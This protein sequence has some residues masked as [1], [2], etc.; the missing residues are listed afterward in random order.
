MCECR[1]CIRV[2]SVYFLTTSFPSPPLSPPR[3]QVLIYNGQLDIIVGPPLT[4]AYLLV[5]PWSGKTEYLSAVKSV[6]RINPSDTDTAGY[7]RTVG[8]FTQVCTCAWILNFK[9]Q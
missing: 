4:E 2:A 3:H 6:W 8:N 5:L 1:M 9:L 7:T